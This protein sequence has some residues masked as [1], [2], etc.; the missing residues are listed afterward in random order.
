M[1]VLH[2]TGN[3]L[4]GFE[5]LARGRSNG[6]RRRPGSADLGNG[7]G[8]SFWSLASGSWSLGCRRLGVPHA[9]N[10][11]ARNTECVAE[12]HSRGADLDE[13]VFN[14]IGP[15]VVHPSGVSCR[16]AFSRAGSRTQ[17]CHR[18][19]DSRA[20]PATGSQAAGAAFGAFVT[21]VVHRMPSR[22]FSLLVE[23]MGFGRVVWKDPLLRLVV[24]S[25]AYL[26]PRLPSKI[27]NAWRT[28][29]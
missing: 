23:D 7:H 14:L 3:V 5:L 13:K 26:V 27:R 11:R 24:L 6:K 29:R 18:P 20:M 17:I 25:A 2:A 16:H 21:G 28:A 15:F 9:R 12:T 22:G 4:G 19:R 10:R 8:F 1:V